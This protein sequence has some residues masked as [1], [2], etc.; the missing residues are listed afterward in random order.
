MA[1]VVQPIIV[2]SQE[3]PTEEV[4]A[5]LLTKAQPTHVFGEK[6]ADLIG[7]NVVMVIGI[8]TSMHMVVML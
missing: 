1:H 7:S 3:I 6:L 8:C 4:M 5:Y 2:S